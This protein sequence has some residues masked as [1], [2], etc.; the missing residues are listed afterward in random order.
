[1]DKFWKKINGVIKFNQTA[2]LK[3]YTSMYT[4]LK[5]KSKKMILKRPFKLVDN[6]V[7]AKT[8]EN[9]RKQR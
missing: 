7:F 1:M 2:S 4:D 6:P 8:M 5:K 9:V 3:P